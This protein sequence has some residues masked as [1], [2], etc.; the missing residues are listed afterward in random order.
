MKRRT[1][2][3]LS[4]QLY[5]M[6]TGSLPVR[7]A[8]YLVTE[9]FVENVILCKVLM[10]KHVYTMFQYFPSDRNA[11][12]RYFEALL[13]QMLHVL[14]IKLVLYTNLKLTNLQ[15]LYFHNYS[16]LCILPIILISYK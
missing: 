7:F 1:T 10:A 12:S 4:V 16:Y 2:V 14:I 15:Y 5:V 3:G 9:Y 13:Y 6:D 8:R 11:K